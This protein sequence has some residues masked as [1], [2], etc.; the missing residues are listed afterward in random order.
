MSADATYRIVIEYDGTQFS[1]FQFQPHLRTVA[2][3]LEAALSRLF[4]R[5][6]K[7][8]AAGRTDAG[9]HAAGQVVSFVA[10]DAFPIGKLAVALNSLLPRDLS[11]RDGALAEPGFSARFSAIDRS[12]T[13]TIFN[14]RE[15]SAL[16]RRR[17]AF[18]H[19]A[20][21]L[22]AMGRAAAPLIGTHDFRTFCGV[23][24]ERGGTVRT[25]HSLEIEREGDFVRLHFRADGFLHRMVRVITGT[26][27]EVGTGRR[28][29]ETLSAVLAALDRRAAGL[30][31]PP[32][33]LCL[34]E[35]RYP[36]FSSR[37]ATLR[38]AQ[39]I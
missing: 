5:P 31:A 10:H 6:I 38:S 20:L 33:G 35:V 2:A 26:L 13:Y 16:H 8:T 25:L 15:P 30:T 34:V 21:D 37:P 32:Q 28:G 36:G 17:S 4:D 9:V 14:R 12:Y 27:I 29:A 1:G 18:E 22:E 39:F 11:A 3:T 19:R 24:P 23:L 7:V